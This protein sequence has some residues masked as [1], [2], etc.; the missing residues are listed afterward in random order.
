MVTIGPQPP[1][2]GVSG[3]YEIR[4]T[5]NYYWYK[6]DQLGWLTTEA[7][8]L[9]DGLY[10]VRLEVF[11]ET[12]AKLT[13][14]AVDYR[15][16]T[17]APPGPLPP[18]ANRCDLVVLVDNKAPTLGLTVPGASGT[19]GVVP[20]S[21]IPGLSVDI[22]VNQPHGRLHSWGLSYVKGI[23]GG[24]GNLGGN[25]QNNGI[26]PLPVAA[27]IPATPMT[28]GLT[29]T[30]SF[31]LTLNAWPLVR[32]GFGAINPVTRTIAIA[33]EKCSP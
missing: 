15:D 4:N 10:T 27:S 25:T 32:N 21:A 5:A 19:C 29:C 28:A 18:M 2:N 17:D 33:I 6:R 30:C 11:D 12:G 1:V 24:S 20:F 16:G 8:G 31:A 9:A 3:L 22:Q 14:A 26:V 13:S 23:T 7:L